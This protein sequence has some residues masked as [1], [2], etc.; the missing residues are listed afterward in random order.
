MNFRGPTAL[1]GRPKNAVCATR[2]RYGR[3]QWMPRWVSDYRLG[4]ECSR[5]RDT[6]PSTEI[7]FPAAQSR[8]VGSVTVPETSQRD[9]GIALSIGVLSCVYLLAFRRATGLKLDEGLSL[10]AAQRILQGQVPYRDFFSLVTPGS[11]YWTA[12]LFRVFGDSILVTRATLVAY[13]GLFSLLTYFLARRVCSR[14]HAAL[15]ACLLTITSLPYYFVAEHNW[16]STVWTCLAL[17][18]AVRLLER[19][20]LSWAFALGFFASLTCLF[21]Q[22]K[23]GG[24]ALGLAAGFLLLSYRFGRRALFTGKRLAALALGLTLPVF[25]TLLYFGVERSLRPMLADWLWPLKHYN[26]VNLVPYGYLPLSPLEWHT[27]HSGSLLWRLFALFTLSP[28]FLIPALPILALMLLGCHLFG[29]RAHRAWDR[30]Q[31]YYVLVC[32]CIA[33]LLLS[34]LVA[35]P[36]LSHIIYLAPIFYL[37]LC[38]ILEGKAF[39]G[40]FLPATRPVIAAYVVLSFSGFGLALLLNAGN[41]RQTLKTRRGTLRTTI[42][43]AVVPYV[44]AHVPE[45]TEIFVYPYQPLYYYLT[46]SNNITSYD[47]LYPGYNTPGQFR[48]AAQ[49]LDAGR[50]TAVLLAPSFMDV[51]LTVFPGTPLRVLARSDPMVNQIF[52]RYRPCKTLKSA[53]GFTDVFMMRK[54][55]SCPGEA[56]TTGYRENVEKKAR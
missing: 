45:G 56:S 34:V 55:L 11:Y 43:D 17:Y 44:Q 27:I 15:G 26:S 19:P 4:D 54:D 20:N 16:D 52:S 28:T 8:G 33:G 39:G 13:G 5:N 23:G 14:S 41:A 1:S 32:S 6:I 42:Q 12:L 2:E 30:E 36:D 49:Q 9:W 37:V 51:A 18:C 35:R 3:G 38:W 48:Q 25:V 7:P 46:G 50:P 22:S 53:E 10:Q 24:L 47:F 21:E 29:L 40:A 31:A